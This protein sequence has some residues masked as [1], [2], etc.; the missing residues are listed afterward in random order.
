VI[1]WL[2]VWGQKT[3][4]LVFWKSERVFLQEIPHCRLSCKCQ[5]SNR[6][7]VLHV[8]C[9]YLINA[10]QIQR[11]RIFQSHRWKWTDFQEGRYQRVKKLVNPI[12][13]KITLKLVK[14]PSFRICGC[15]LIEWQAFKSRKNKRACMGFEDG[16]PQNHTFSLIFMIFL[17]LATQ[18]VFVQTFWNSIHLLILVWWNLFLNLINISALSPSPFLNSEMTNKHIFACQSN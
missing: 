17:N 16:V 3:A 1:I 18:L 9:G 10:L 14:V 11:Y 13:W 15:I 6:Y 5:K 2:V 8:S 7:V 12:T 4:F